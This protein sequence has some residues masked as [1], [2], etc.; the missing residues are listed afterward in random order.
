VGKAAFL[1]EVSALAKDSSDSHCSL[2]GKSG[3]DIGFGMGNQE[4]DKRQEVKSKEV[5][6]YP[7]AA[8]VAQGNAEQ[9]A[10]VTT[11]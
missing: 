8:L 2:A 3:N 6:E 11:A 7:I 5:I 1:S 4:L 10:K 9:P